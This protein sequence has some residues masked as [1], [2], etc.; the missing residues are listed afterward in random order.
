M[1]KNTLERG[2]FTLH[3]KRRPH[4]LNLVDSVNVQKSDESEHSCVTADT[5]K[6]CRAMSLERYRE[7]KRKRAFKKTIRYEMR[8]LNAENRPRVKVLQSLQISM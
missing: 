6:Q 7:K 5:E 1:D 2:K 4:P 8:R 3:V